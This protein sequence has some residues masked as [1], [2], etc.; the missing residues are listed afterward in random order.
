M[1]K[2]NAGSRLGVGASPTGKENVKRQSKISGFFTPK[3]AKAPPRTP[4]SE[5]NGKKGQASIISFFSPKNTSKKPSKVKENVIEN[6]KTDKADTN[7]T[8]I[9]EKEITDYKIKKCKVNILRIQDPNIQVFCKREEL[10]T[11][12]I[13]ADKDEDKNSDSEIEVDNK[14]A[15]EEEDSEDE[16]KED[17]SDSEEESESDWEGDSDDGFQKA[18]KKPQVRAKKKGKAANQ[19][20]AL[21]APIIIP[22]AMKSELSA[23]EKL[24]DENIKAREDMLAALMADFQDF[25]KDAGIKTKEERT[26]KK[27]RTFDEAF[28]CSADM[29]LERRKSSRL[30]DKP[31]DGSEPKYGSETWGDE[32]RE[33]REFVVAEE[34]SDYDEDDYTNHEIRTKR[35]NPTRWEKDPNVNILMPEDVTPSMLKKVCDGGKKTY[36]TSIGTT[37]HQCRQKTIDTKTICRSGECAGVRGQFCG[38]CLRNRYGE[39][40]REALM[41]P[42]WKCPPCRNFCNCSICRNRK[43]VGATGIITQLARSKGFDNVAEYLEYLVK[44]KKDGKIKKKKK[45]KK[46]V[47]DNDNDMENDDEENEDAVENEKEKKSGSEEEV[48]KEKN[49]NEIKAIGESGGKDEASDDAN[50]SDE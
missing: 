17:S 46:E 27:K 18:V 8:K 3:A 30:A 5:N 43:G 28:R 33:K 29:P 23:Y 15:K 1:D 10:S 9:Q 4:L 2:E 49:E 50:E 13:P 21:N 42:Y 22:G 35:S 7:F 37:C 41:D 19:R 16:E 20:A 48:K 36:N 47:E 25:K 45:K 31:E 14:E 40:A 26:A 34:L 39:D 24:R 32:S 6:V 44:S 12:E 11:D 38:I